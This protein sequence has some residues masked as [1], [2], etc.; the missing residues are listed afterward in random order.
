MT[1]PSLRKDASY[2][3]SVVLAVKM[4]L[5]K[6]RQQKEFSLTFVG[7]DSILVAAAKHFEQELVQVLMDPEDYIKDSLKDDKMNEDKWI[8]ELAY[9]G[10]SMESIM[11]ETGRSKSH[12]EKVLSSTG[13]ALSALPE[14]KEE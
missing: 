3:K 10:R 13:F 4:L 11:R 6:T 9:E 2:S 5:R 12:I 14:H 7:E 8:E 1:D